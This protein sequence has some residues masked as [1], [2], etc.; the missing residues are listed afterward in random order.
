MT[1]PVHDQIR[2]Y[3]TYVDEQ[4]APIELAELGRSVPAGSGPEPRVRRRYIVAFAVALVLTLAVLLP[5]VLLTGNDPEIAT[6]PPPTPM[7]TTTLATTTLPPVSTTLGAI[8]P[9]SLSID[10]LPSV[11]SAGWTWV[12][13]PRV[14]PSQIPQ[15]TAPDGSWIYFDVGYNCP[16]V[17]PTFYLRENLNHDCPVSPGDAET[18]GIAA[19]DDP[20][21][22]LLTSRDGQS[23]ERSEVS[24]FEGEFTWIKSWPSRSALLVIGAAS[25]ESAGSSSEFGTASVSHDGLVW[26]SVSPTI[27]DGLSARLG[28]AIIDPVVVGD[29]IVGQSGCPNS[30]YLV[31][32]QD[33]GGTFSLVDGL[34][35]TTAEFATHELR[36]AGGRNGL[37]PDYEPYRA[38]AHTVFTLNGVFYALQHLDLKAA[39]IVWSSPDGVTWSTLGP[40][41]GLG[42]PD[43]RVANGWPFGASPIDLGGTALVSQPATRDGVGDHS[44]AQF[45]TSVDGL[46]WNELAIPSCL[47]RARDDAQMSAFGNA[48]GAARWVLFNYC[49]AE[50]IGSV[51]GRWNGEDFE[52]FSARGDRSAETQFHATGQMFWRRDVNQD[53]FLAV[54]PGG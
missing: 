6:T 11:D 27:P 28:S 51:F 49:S 31:V 23:W 9:G 7:P 17:T 5:V 43:H 20:M 47:G 33:S 10:D 36:Q 30:G 52:W 32:S 15:G 40:A 3:S 2:D 50:N 29:T 45:F 1:A 26:H 24:G 16:A 19:T 21:E 53:V 18:R 41:S 4:V 12:P 54:P 14:P 22:S 38:L 46:M 42:G 13:W 37:C 8:A 35:G 34:P 44:P 39:P 25:V 48:I